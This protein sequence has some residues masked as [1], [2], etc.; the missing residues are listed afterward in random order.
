V[1]ADV[2][3]LMDE[4]GPEKMVCVSDP[5]TGVKG[6]LAI[7]NTARGV[8]KGGIGALT[9]AMALDLAPYG[10][11]VNALMPRSVDTDSQRP[12]YRAASGV[13]SPLGTVG[14]LHQIA[15][16]ALFLASDDASYIT[17]DVI[18]LDGGMP[19]QQRSATV[20][21]RPPADYPKVEDL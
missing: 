17:G 14:G 12:E 1:T 13:N 5:R 21:I 15:G 6:V 18:R 2:L 4:W 20:D 11:R 8:A 9:R 10:I 7:D 16:A 3:S 19:A